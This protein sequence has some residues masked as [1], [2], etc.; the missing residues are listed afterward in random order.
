M[1]NLLRPGRR[2]LRAWLPRS[3]PARAT[4]RCRGISRRWLVVGSAVLR[5]C[6]GSLTADL[7]EGVTGRRE[8]HRTTASGRKC[9]LCRAF[10]SWLPSIGSAWLNHALPRSAPST[11]EAAVQPVDHLR[12]LLEPLRDPA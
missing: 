8:G 12:H 6:R 2:G 4:G 10:D 7:A 9:M 3:L 1:D 5:V 11:R